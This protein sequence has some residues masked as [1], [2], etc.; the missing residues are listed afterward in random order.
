M[1]WGSRWSNL[2]TWFHDIK[3]YI[4]NREY[5]TG[6]ST[7]EKKTIR[8]LAL[9]FFITNDI[10]YKRTDDGTLLCCVESKE[11]QWVMTEV[12][13]GVCG[14]H[15]NG[16]NMAKQIQ[17]WGYF[18]L[19]MERDCIDYI[20]S[21]HKCWIYSDKIHVPPILLHN[22]TAP[23]SFVMWGIDVIGLISPIAWNSRRFILVA[24]DYFTKWIKDSSFTNITKKRHSSCS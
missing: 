23:W 7:T 22:L 1:K 15:S 12:H 17:R 8:H 16:H 4:K 20:W 9:S 11:A 21:C 19:S 10:L 14:T 3:N 18:W 24:I 6:A 13:E 2:A 5:P